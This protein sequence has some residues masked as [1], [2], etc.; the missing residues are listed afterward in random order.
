M[1]I[2]GRKIADSI[3]VGVSKDVANLGFVP[4]FCDVLVGEDPVSLSYVKIKGKTAERVGI[5]FSAVHLPATI[6]QEALEQEVQRLGANSRMCGLIIQLPLPLHL[7]RQTILDT[8]DTRIDVDCLSSVNISEF[9][10]GRGAIHPPTAIAIM[11]VLRSTGVTLIEKKVVIVGNGNLVGKPIA[12][13]LRRHGVTFTVVDKNT[14][15]MDDVARSADVLICGTGQ[16]KI[17]TGTMVKPGA[18]VVDAGTAEQNGGIVGDVDFE[19][20]APVAG[21][22]SPVPGGVGPVTVACLLKN[23]AT[24]AK[25]KKGYDTN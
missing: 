17:I 7:E 9:F 24:V 11:E 3:L 10:N 15:N 18:I 12:E 21:F 4:V 19:S 8:I 2:D 22:I 16:P 14:P 25:K 13:L 1:V 6:T 20:V 23:V 5:E